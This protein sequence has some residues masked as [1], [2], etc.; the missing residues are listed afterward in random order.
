M[1]ENKHR[2]GIAC[3]HFQWGARVARKRG[4]NCMCVCVFAR[5]CQKEIKKNAKNED[6]ID[7]GIS[8]SW[9]EDKNTKY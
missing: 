1:K 7:D 3:I 5:V 9:K 2:N 8:I 6:S 4:K